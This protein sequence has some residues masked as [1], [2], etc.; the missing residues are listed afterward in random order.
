M[1]KEKRNDTGKAFILEISSR[2]R[3]GVWVKL[4]LS[5]SDRQERNI[6]VLK[7]TVTITS[8]KILAKYFGQ[9]ADEQQ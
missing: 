2:I 7:I 8:V 4:L 3:L 1:Y 9:V 6:G 5:A